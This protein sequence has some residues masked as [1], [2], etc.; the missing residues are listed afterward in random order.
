MSDDTKVSD[1]DLMPIVIKLHTGDELHTTISPE[2][3][4]WLRRDIDNSEDVVKIGDAFIRTYL[5][6]YIIPLHGRTHVRKFEISQLVAVSP[7]SLHED[8]ASQS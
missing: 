1:D 8:D 2:A 4:E 6:D 3:Y 5:I 7:D